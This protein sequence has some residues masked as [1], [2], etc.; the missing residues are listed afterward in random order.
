MGI[1]QGFVKDLSNALFFQEQQF[2]RAPVDYY[3]WK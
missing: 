3:F 1:F 2:S